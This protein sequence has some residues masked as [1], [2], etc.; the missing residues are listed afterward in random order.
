MFTPTETNLGTV[1]EEVNF[2]F[3][4]TYEVTDE[5][6]METV[7]YPVIIT[8]EEVVSTVLVSGN[9]IYGYYTDSFNNN[10]QYLN[11][12]K[13]LVT[14]DKFGKVVNLYEMVKYGADRSRTKIF[15]YT[16]KAMD[17]E[18]VVDS[19]VYTITVQNDW[20]TGKNTLQSYV[21][22]TDASSS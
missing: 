17:E 21:R 19:Q 10:I 2:S 9:T 6:T 14:T 22:S 13:Q 3:S 15:N 4:V 12:G 1:N 7:S 16:A 5:M 11:Q 8:A 18:T 20:T